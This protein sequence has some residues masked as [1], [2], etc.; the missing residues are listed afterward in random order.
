MNRIACFIHWHFHSPLSTTYT[1]VFCHFSLISSH[2]VSFV[3]SFDFQRSLTQ[4]IMKFFYCIDISFIEN[5]LRILTLNNMILLLSR[6][7]LVARQ[8][9]TNMHHF[10]CCWNFT[11]QRMEYTYNTYVNRA[12]RLDR[13]SVSFSLNGKLP[14]SKRRARLWLCVKFLFIKLSKL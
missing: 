6:C 13:F 4:I 8:P 2:F 1:P 7:V 9:C 12:V 3:C 11:T 10:F 5:H 14:R